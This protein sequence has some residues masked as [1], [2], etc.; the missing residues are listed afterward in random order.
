KTMKPT[1]KQLATVLITVGLAGAAFASQA[2]E[3]R[4]NDAYEAAGANVSIVSALNLA[5]D[6]VPGTAVGA[7]FEDNE[8]GHSFWKVEILASN[9]QVRDLKIDSTTGQVLSNLADRE[10]TE[11]MEGMEDHD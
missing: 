9:Q 7:K 10:D 6:E 3:P 11:Y 1:K 2:K 4:M 8:N 5:L